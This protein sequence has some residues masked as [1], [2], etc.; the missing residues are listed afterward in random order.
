MRDA[1]GTNKI[2]KDQKL[3]IEGE[4]AEVFGPQPGYGRAD[5]PYLACRGN[6][7]AINA[8][9]R[10]KYTIDDEPFYYAKMGALGYI[11]SHKDFKFTDPKG[12]SG[13]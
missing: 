3:R 8:Q 11:I 4:L 7:A 6:P 10:E 12:E 5:I 9:E 1:I 2:F 13:K